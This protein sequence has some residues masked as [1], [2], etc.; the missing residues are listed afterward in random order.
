MPEKSEAEEIT[1]ASGSNLAFALSLLP[2]G[3]RRDMRCFY[4]FCRRVDDIVDDDDQPVADRRRALNHWRDVIDGRAT[5]GPGLE[6][7]I[8]RVRETHRIPARLFVDIIEG[9][10]MDTEP[11]TY[12]TVEELLHY[13]YHAAGAVGL[14]SVEI[15]GYKDKACLE[16]AKHLG[17]ALQLTNIIRDVAEDA[18]RGRVYL[19]ESHLLAA[20]LSMEELLGGEPNPERLCQALHMLTLCAEEEYALATAALPKADRSNMAAA[21]TM[22]RIYHRLLRLMTRDRFRVFEKR[23]RVPKSYMIRQLAR[24]W[25]TRR[26]F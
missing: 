11:R 5:A 15:F 24:G 21:E 25:M 22:R 17:N 26:G 12:R 9:M 14:V 23:Y 16:Y 3:C 8:V 18:G 20:E 13:C 2:P 7:D 1:K 6:A 10:E 4:A 19:P